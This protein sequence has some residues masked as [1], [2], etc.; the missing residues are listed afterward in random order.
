MPRRTASS[1][2]EEVAGDIE[3]EILRAR[4]PEGPRLGLRPDLPDRHQV[5]PGVMN[6]TLRL[7]RERELVTVKQGQAGGVYV[8]D[9]P[10]GVR[11]GALDLW[12]QGMTVPPL[13]VFESRSLLED[14]FNTLALERSTADDLPVIE[15][16][17]RSMQDRAADARGFF[18]ANVEFHRAIARATRVE[19]LVGLHDAMVTVL[20]GSLVRAVWTEG[21]EATVDHN[22]RV[23]AQIL[24]AIRAGDR[25]RLE[26]AT[27][28]HHIDMVSISEPEKSPAA[29][30]DLHSVDTGRTTRRRGCSAG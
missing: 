11:L 22:L 28:L 6:E 29:P 3:M 14:M 10:P 1:R 8:A 20:T 9:L 2:A 26:T 7:L 13:Q 18:E 16:A 25:K 30:L 15:R 19:V 27:R 23:H 21:H 5:S 4:L 17:L 24:E 12:F